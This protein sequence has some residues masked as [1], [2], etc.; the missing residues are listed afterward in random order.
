MMIGH[1]PL[2]PLLVLLSVTRACCCLSEQQ[3]K[4]VMDFGREGYH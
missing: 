1:S 2:T 4:I 3:V